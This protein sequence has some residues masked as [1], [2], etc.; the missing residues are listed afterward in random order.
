MTAGLALLV[1]ALIGMG[2]LVLELYGERRTSRAR[3][4][5]YQT[6][7]E[8]RIAAQRETTA[9]LDAVL[10]Q[11]PDMPCCRG[12]GGYHEVRCGQ[13]LPHEPVRV[14]D[15]EQRKLVDWEV[16]RERSA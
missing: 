6:D 10:R 9:R 3:L 11:W 1:L 13:R 2:G 15:P 12:S 14:W 16:Y 8:Q 5:A 4:A 7:F